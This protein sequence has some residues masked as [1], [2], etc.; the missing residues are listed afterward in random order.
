MTTMTTMT[1][2]AILDFLKAVYNTRHHGSCLQS[3]HVGR[4]GR[5]MPQFELSICN[6]MN[7][8]ANQPRVR[9]CLKKQTNKN[10]PKRGYKEQTPWTFST[11]LFLVPNLQPS[12]SINTWSSTIVKFK[13]VVLKNSQ[14]APCSSSHTPLLSLKKILCVAFCT[15]SYKVPVTLHKPRVNL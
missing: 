13:A 12:Y 1:T 7:F 9:H 10:K 5:S 2:M 14:S 15:T 3:Q 11:L 8:R 6:R 4:L